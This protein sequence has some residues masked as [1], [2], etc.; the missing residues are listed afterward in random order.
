MHP[1]M[2]IRPAVGQVAAVDVDQD[3]WVRTRKRKIDIWKSVRGET[4][5]S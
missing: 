5:A 1:A 3:H 4:C 2:S